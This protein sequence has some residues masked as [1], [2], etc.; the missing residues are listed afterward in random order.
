MQTGLLEVSNPP[1]TTQDEQ[2]R[3]FLDLYTLK[4]APVVIML[5]KILYWAFVQSI[6]IYRNGKYI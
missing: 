1:N 3:S 4:K 2:P 5:L 6:L